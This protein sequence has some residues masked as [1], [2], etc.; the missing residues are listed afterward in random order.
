MFVGTEFLKSR[1]G[2]EG[3]DLRIQDITWTSV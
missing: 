3:G 2:D 1:I